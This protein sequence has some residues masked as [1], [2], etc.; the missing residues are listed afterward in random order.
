MVEGRQDLRL[1]LEPGQAIRISREG[2]RQDLQGDL[3]AQ[4]RVGGLP[5]LSHA[6][7]ADEAGHGVVPEAGAGTEGHGGLDDLANHTGTAV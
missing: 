2:V 6:A 3:A 4:L 1:P 5:D 7:L